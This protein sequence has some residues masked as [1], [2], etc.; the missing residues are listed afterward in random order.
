MVSQKRGKLSQF[1]RIVKSLM[2]VSHLQNKNTFI[3]RKNNQ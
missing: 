1:Y 2:L 3:R